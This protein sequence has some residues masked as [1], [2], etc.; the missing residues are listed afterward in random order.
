MHDSFFK[1]FIGK[2]MHD[3]WYVKS[4]HQVVHGQQA[5]GHEYIGKE[6]FRVLEPR[7]ETI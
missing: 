3:M 1:K 7:I 2:F 5:E 6:I 4:S